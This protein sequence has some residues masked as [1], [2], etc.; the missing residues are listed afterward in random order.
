MLIN[1]S[2]TTTLTKAKFVK[3]YVEKM[4]T[5]AKKNKL[6]ANRILAA[7]LKR[8]AFSK[9]IKEVAPGFE[10]RYGGYTRIIKLSKRRGDAAPMA[11]IE[12]L[13]Y[14]KIIPKTRISK[15]VKKEKIEKAKVA[16]KAKSS[17]QKTSKIGKG[18]Q[19]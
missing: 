14:E 11:K 5:T 17:W 4:V 8:D 16:K 1:G 13:K 3:P 19:K 2:I 18:R 10:N 7:S 12:F 9:L 6:W 15:S